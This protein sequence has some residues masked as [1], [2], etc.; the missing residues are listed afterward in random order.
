LGSGSGTVTE[1]DAGVTHTYVCRVRTSTTA[2][3]LLGASAGASGLAMSTVNDPWSI[4]VPGT[5]DPDQ[6]HIL[7]V[8]FN[9]SGTDLSCNETRFP[10][11]YARLVIDGT[12]GRI[13]LSTNG[14]SGALEDSVTIASGWFAAPFEYGNAVQATIPAPATAGVLR[15]FL[16]TGYNQSS[17]SWQWQ[18]T[19]SSVTFFKDLGSDPGTHNIEATV[20]ALQALGVDGSFVSVEP[21][22]TTAVK[23]LHLGPNPCRGSL[24]CTVDLPRAAVTTLDLLDVNGRQWKRLESGYMS[25]GAHRFRWTLQGPLPNGIYFVRLRTGNQA[26]S[27]R[28]VSMGS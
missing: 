9:L 19:T 6:H 11:S 25:A 28:F 12:M 23:L 22:S 7:S 4:T 5:G 20:T 27:V 16:A 3:V 13:S 14:L 17:N 18:D 15:A 24:E 21:I 10:A 2:S 26:Q 1:V 8:T